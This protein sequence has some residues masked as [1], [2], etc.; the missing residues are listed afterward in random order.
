MLDSFDIMASRTSRN[1]LLVLFGVF[2]FAPSFYLIAGNGVR[3]QA[4]L[5]G[6][7]WPEAE[8]VEE[9]QPPPD[10]KIRPKEGEGQLGP[11]LPKALEES[12]QLMSRILSGM[13]PTKTPPQAHFAWKKM[14]RWALSKTKETPFKTR[15]ARFAKRKARLPPVY[16]Q[17]PAS[18]KHSKRHACMPVGLQ[19]GESK[20]QGEKHRCA[21][22]SYFGDEE[23]SEE[24]Q[25]T[26][27]HF[28]ANR[29]RKTDWD[30]SNSERMAAAY[31]NEEMLRERGK[32]ATYKVKSHVLSSKPYYSYDSSYSLSSY[33]PQRTTAQRAA[34][35]RRKR[36]ISRF[37][38][39]DQNWDAAFLN[40]QLRARKEEGREN[41]PRGRYLQKR[42]EPKKISIR[43]IRLTLTALKTQ[44]KLS[45]MVDHISDP[46]NQMSKDEKLNYMHELLNELT[47]FAHLLQ[48]Q[49]AQQ[50]QS[51][52]TNPPDTSTSQS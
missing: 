27:R 16:R 1:T 3:D 46:S 40:S 34:P 51:N 19:N 11:Y 15:R 25:A 33:V 45:E 21:R 9:R 26:L 43:T 13:H 22:S 30:R 41:E 29:G 38:A 28:R 4:T 50:S 6:L 20:I 10:I 12:N 2:V 5:E 37:R 32:R 39:R 18:R 24:Q 52:T 35:Q 47:S 7:E 31:E 36:S 17:G 8:S 49:V 44:E 23:G 42:E 14:K 48:Q